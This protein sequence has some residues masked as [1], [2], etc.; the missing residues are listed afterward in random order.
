MK[1]LGSRLKFSARRQVNWRLADF[2]KLLRS[3]LDMLVEKST[4]IAAWEMGAN[5]CLSVTRRPSKRQRKHLE[6]SAAATH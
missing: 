1:N 6:S 2:R 4:S 5:D 3:A